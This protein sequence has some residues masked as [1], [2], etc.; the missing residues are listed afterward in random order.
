MA[1]SYGEWCGGLNE[2]SPY[3]L[4]YFKAFSLVGGTFG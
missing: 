3:K 2:K 4:V 1:E